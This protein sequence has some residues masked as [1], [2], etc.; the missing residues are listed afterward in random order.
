[1][2]NISQMNETQLYEHGVM[3]AQTAV[4]R[5]D[6]VHRLVLGMKHGLERQHQYPHLLYPQLGELLHGLWRHAWFNIGMEKLPIPFL[7]HNEAPSGSGH[8]KP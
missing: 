1:M 7:P 4:E 3:I 6:A 8:I 5:P 2:D